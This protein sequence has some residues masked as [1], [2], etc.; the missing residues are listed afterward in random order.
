M[1]NATANFI[2][3]ISFTSS[4]NLA[5]DWK[6]FKAQLNIYTMAKKFDKVN[7]EEKLANTFRLMDS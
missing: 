7:K 6:L 2:S 1:T 3:R 4:K 5:S